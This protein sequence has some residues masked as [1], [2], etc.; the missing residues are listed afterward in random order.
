MNWEYKMNIFEFAS[1]I[2]GRISNFQT[3]IAAVIGAFIAWRFNKRK[4]ELDEKAFKRDLFY[5]FN[6][7]YSE[8]NGRLED[9]HNWEIETE[10]RSS[11]GSD[12]KLEDYWEEFHRK[13]PPFKSDYIDAVYDYLN[14]CSEQHYWYQKKFVDEDVWACWQNGM[15]AW[16]H[17]LFVM[18]KAIEDEFNLGT[19]FYTKDFLNI[20]R[21]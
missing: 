13:D 21:K 3:L 6:S 17:R 1:D 11:N 15:K 10:I 5:Q 18:Q 9:C 12:L 20:F 2:L 8:L 19:V 16:H 7:R 14:M 4:S